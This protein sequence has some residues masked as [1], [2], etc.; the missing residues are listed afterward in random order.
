MAPDTEQQVENR[1][2][3]MDLLNAVNANVNIEL[4]NIL[5]NI[6]KYKQYNSKQTMN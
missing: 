3:V 2:K 5:T 1:I 6:H 4:H